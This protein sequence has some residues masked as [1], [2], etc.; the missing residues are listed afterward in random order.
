MSRPG[1]LTAS[2]F[3]VAM[4]LPVPVSFAGAERDPGVEAAILPGA[5][6]VARIDLD[7]VRSSG[8]LDSLSAGDSESRAIPMGTWTELSRRLEASGLPAGDVRE[9]F[10]FARI[11][12][13]E[14]AA[15]GKRDRSGPVPAL[16]AVSLA[17]PIST[18]KLAAALAA[19]W[20]GRTTS[21]FTAGDAAGIELVSAK[22]GERSIFAAT[23][24]K[25]TTLYLAT[26]REI[27]EGALARDRSGAYEKLSAD[28][29]R[30]DDSLPAGLDARVILLA[31]SRLTAKLFDKPGRGTGNRPATMAESMLEPFRQLGSLTLAVDLTDDA[32][33]A[34]VGDLSGEDEARSAR[35]LMATMILPNLSKALSARFGS[36]VAFAESLTVDGEGSTARL[37]LRLSG[38][39]IRT[40]FA[41]VNERESKAR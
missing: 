32:R 25:G 37:N 18:E 39:D 17:N 24:R 4:T 9:I 8:F 33:I 13:I 21:P 22:P 10:V 34:L 30:I 3:T 5:D 12:V 29:T 26:D 31:P 23:S 40:L 15:P 16:A 35:T 7:A 38:G 6:L 2:L 11:D 36:L 20:E 19:V 14:F 41:G 1:M 27:L 28:L